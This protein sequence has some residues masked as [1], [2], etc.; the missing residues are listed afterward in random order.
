MHGVILDPAPD[1]INPA[2]DSTATVPFCGPVAILIARTALPITS[3]LRFW[4]LDPLGVSPRGLLAGF[5]QNNERV[6]IVDAEAV[7][8]DLGGHHQG[9][10][11]ALRWLA[12]AIPMVNLSVILVATTRVPLHGISPRNLPFLKYR[13]LNF[14]LDGRL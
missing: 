10:G 2:R 12:P 4:P 6:R 3:A 7:H 11:R 9:F 13:I 8:P 14:M 1:P 5:V